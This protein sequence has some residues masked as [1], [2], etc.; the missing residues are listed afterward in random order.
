MK[1][2]TGAE[3][4][5][6][7]YTLRFD[8]LS[9]EEDRQKEMVTGEI[10]VLRDG[11]VIDHMR[12]AKWFF[13]KHESEPTSEVAIRRAPAEDLYITLGNY[14]LAEG[15]ATLKLVVNPI[16]DWIWFGFMLL[17]IGTGIALLPE[18]VLE[19][20]TAGATATVG[21]ATRPAGAAG[22]ALWL[23][24]GAG[25]GLMLGLPRAAAAQMTT[26]SEEPPDPVGADENWLVRNII[27]QCGT[28]RHNLLDCATENCGH[29]NGDR[30]AIR[31]LLDQGR[32]REQVIQYFIE[33]YGGQVALAAPI[34]KGFN[35]LAWLFPY[36]LGL[37]AATGLGYAAYRLARKPPSASPPAG[38]AASKLSD[39]SASAKDAVD[40][41]L[42]DKLDDEL[43]NLD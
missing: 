6:G 38:D 36:S 37:A 23:A 11:K 14:D 12:P 26:A 39:S 31:R 21:A 28:C 41:D 15:N 9:H 8:R 30:I 20:L 42:A 13:H 10:T 4:T 17:A 1:M 3:T 27:C 22:I 32:T 7:K 16:I 5:I 25:G 24:L 19:R 18:A 33:K 29:A 43:R 2:L 40:P 34:D 35:R